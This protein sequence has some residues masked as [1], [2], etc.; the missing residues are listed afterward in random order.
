MAFAEPEE[1]WSKG[2]YPTP[3]AVSGKVG[4]SLPL[5]RRDGERVGNGGM[6]FRLSLPLLLSNLRNE[7]KGKQGKG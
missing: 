1:I 3:P 7:A 5:S 2:P 4:N 6:V